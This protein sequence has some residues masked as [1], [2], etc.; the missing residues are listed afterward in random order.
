MPSEVELQVESLSSRVALL[1]GRFDSSD[2]R[3]EE[4]A[5]KLS[6]LMELN[7]AQ[8][9]TLANIEDLQEKRYEALSKAF[10]ERVLPIL[11]PILSALGAYVASHIH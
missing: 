1:E 10:L 7:K 5:K 6:D 9:T 2:K 11:L 3:A 4:F 8:S